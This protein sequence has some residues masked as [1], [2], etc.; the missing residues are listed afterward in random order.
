[1]K[2]IVL[3]LTLCFVSCG[4]PYDGETIITLNLK[5]V[6]A[7]NAP[8]AN[9]KMYL[10][11]D[12]EL[13]GVDNTTY[14]KTSSSEGVFNFS[15]FKPTGGTSIVLEDSPEF[16]PVRITGINKNNF[17]GLYWDLGTINL[18]KDYEITTFTVLLNKQ[19]ANNTVEKITV[20]AIK[21]ESNYDIATGINPYYGYFQTVYQLKKNQNF[22]LQYDL[23][24]TTTQAVQK[25]SIPLSI[26]SNESSYTINY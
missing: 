8:L 6:N 9:E 5:V 7:N 16:L 11:T 13:D 26:G 2:K 17:E 4:I 21:Y 15:M 14:H 12:F 25:I 1:M 20:N 22:I 24:N 3:I 23:K 19:T 10:S 18:L